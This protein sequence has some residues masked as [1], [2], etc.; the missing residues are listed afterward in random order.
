MLRLL[1]DAYASTEAARSE[2]QARARILGGILQE[3]ERE[4]WYP[5]M[6]W[7]HRTFESDRAVFERC[8]EEGTVKPVGMDDC[9]ITIEGL[10]ECGGDTRARRELECC[11]L[12]VKLCQEEFRRG[13]QPRVDLEQAAVQLKNVDLAALQRAALVLLVH[14]A[15]GIQ[16][17]WGKDGAGRPS[18]LVPMHRVLDVPSDLTRD[19]RG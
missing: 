12:L 4:G 11:E 17:E 5:N 2:Q 18:A 16:V 15:P 8:I 13:D 19:A 14:E 1:L 10:R 7:V 9:L 3:I 6:Q